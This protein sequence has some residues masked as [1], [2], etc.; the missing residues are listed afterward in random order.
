[1]TSGERNDSAWVTGYM[2]QGAGEA[3]RVISGGQK[4]ESP[5]RKC[6]S[7]AQLENAARVNWA[8]LISHYVC[9][10]RQFSMISLTPVRWIA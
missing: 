8:C 3:W 1:V 4:D 2:A 6:N 7:R 5:I 9:S 10:S